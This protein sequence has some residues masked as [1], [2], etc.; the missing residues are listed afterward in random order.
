[1]SHLEI[2]DMLEGRYRIDHP[3]ARGGMSTVYRCVDMR[4]ARAVAVKVMD[5]RYVDDPVF[6]HRF[7]REARA[8][9]QLTHPNLVGVYDFGS[10][11][12]V[13]FLVM[14][15]IT[16]GTLR[17][18]LAERGPMPPHAA[19]AV[20]RSVLTGLAAAH[21][22]DMIHR[23]LK[24]DN[25]LIGAD[26]SVKLADFGLVRA[27]SVATGRTDKIVGTAAYLSPEQV[28]GDELTPAS[29]VYSA[30][31]M[32]FEL[33]TGTTPFSGG[34]ALEHAYARL[35]D[36]VPAPSSRISGVPGLFDELVAG[37]TVREPEQRFRDASEFL[38][39]L[40]DVARELSLPT[41]RV[42]VPHDAAAHRAA[43]V[44]TDTT[45]LAGVLAP[46]SVL[47][48][49]DPDRRAPGSEDD[50]TLLAADGGDGADEDAL[51]DDRFGGRDETVFDAEGYDAEGYRAETYDPDGYDADGHGPG[52]RDSRDPRD[53]DWG[54]PDAPGGPVGPGPGGY[55]TALLP[56]AGD[57]YG[58][59]GRGPGYPEHG[60]AGYPAAGA[61]GY[62]GPYDDRHPDRYAGDLPADHDDALPD[63]EGRATRAEKPLS[64]RSPWRLAAWLTV[65]A[66]ILAA[67][68]LGGWW[69]GSGRYGEIPQVIGLDRSSA[70]A[71]V[72]QAGFSA[73]TREVYDDDIPVDFST[74]TEPDFPDREVRGREVTVLVSQGRPTVPEIQE[75]A[76]PARYQQ[77]LTERTLNWE[78]GEEV[79]S[80]DVAEGDLARTEPAAGNAV[81]VGSTVTLH[82]SK[83]PA[84]VEVPH[85]AGMST[86]QATDVLE[87][88]GLKVSGMT[89][90]FDA[91][92]PAGHVI[93]TD[94]P[95]GTATTR[96]SSVQLTVSNAVEVPDVVGEKIDTA[97][98]KLAD[99]GL[100]VNVE[101]D[102]SRTADSA[103]EVLAVSPS[104]GDLVDPA[105]P[106][107]TVT[108]PGKVKVPRVVGK[109]A[110]DARE[111][112]E[113]AGLK[114]SP[115]SGGG[116]VYRQSPRAGGTASPD[117]TVNLSTTGD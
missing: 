8:M 106:Q 18:L 9:A 82:L 38:E 67:V 96:G 15:L 50:T 37:A 52:D 7:R 41:F 68:A 73:V 35:D 66:V 87:G 1:M 93:S 79:H 77:L 33:L 36:D 20:M 62:G 25:V 47:S 4:L 17:E 112:I 110:A 26:H 109:K 103:D 92:T 64:N 30:G 59:D 70:V 40:D 10:D 61:D 76:N 14:E 56:A 45:G 43:A 88:A 42:P 31:V 48:F 91:E 84:P 102:D 55:G 85:V 100:T 63:E 44:P 58:A 111:A 54:G 80:D 89:E 27:A 107:V 6:R 23:D 83:G 65:V 117:D 99:A 11:G 51:D 81:P 46:T 5:D 101:R 94:P 57:P 72:E 90:K 13:I 39:A 71:Q 28:R 34:T 114:P 49:R 78:Y 108:L 12:D 105:D 16:G 22:A 32:L 98:T 75:G 53:A 29:D 2:G 95:T 69:L 19:A 3:I 74:G 60:T 97:R 115:A 24:P 21:S 104:A 86:G 113:E 116:R